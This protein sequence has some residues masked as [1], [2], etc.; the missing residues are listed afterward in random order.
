MSKMDSPTPRNDCAED[1][2]MPSGS[3]LTSGLRSVL[4]VDTVQ[5][6]ADLNPVDFLTPAATVDKRT[7]S[8]V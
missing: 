2:A 8:N 6:E 1:R 3:A 7:A 4:V 5:G